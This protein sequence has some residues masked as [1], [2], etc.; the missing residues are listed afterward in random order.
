V[1]PKWNREEPFAFFNV[2]ELEPE[3]NAETPFGS[4]L[5]QRL[6]SAG[7]ISG[8]STSLVG[9]PS[10]WETLVDTGDATAEFFVIDG[11]LTIDGARLAVG[12][13]GYLPRGGG[14]AQ[15]ATESGAHAYVFWTPNM[16]LGDAEDLPGRERRTVSFWDEPWHEGLLDKKLPQRWK[17]LR[18]PDS[19]TG[20]HG[21][22]A[23]L[24]RVMQWLPGFIAPMEHWHS[25][26]EELIFLSGDWLAERGW[27]GPGTFLGNP[28]GWWHAPVAT[29]DGCLAIVHSESP[30]DLE[31]RECDW[32]PTA[33]REYLDRASWLEQPQHMG[34]DAFAKFGLRVPADVGA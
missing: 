19:G 4:G 9:F 11:E 18:V 13:Y 27:V 6:L 20:K 26:W 7:A 21:S 24:L 30:L 22:R 23:G 31:Q 10:G 16:P 14:S 12:G 32:G 5:E 17:S 33:M 28:G 25:D 34:R 8:A 2:Y 29:R 3:R 15:I 1:Q